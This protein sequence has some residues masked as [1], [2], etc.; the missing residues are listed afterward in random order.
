V[1]EAADHKRPAFF[2]F[3]RAPH[4][5]ALHRP[6]ARSA[7]AILVVQLPEVGLVQLPP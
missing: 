1:A 4:L 5:P 2:L 3:G 7:D 6:E